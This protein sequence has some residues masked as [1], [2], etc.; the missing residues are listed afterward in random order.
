MPLLA[1]ESI[2]LA[3]ARPHDWRVRLRLPAVA[4]AISFAAASCSRS[5]L[6]LPPSRP[7]D[8]TGPG[9]SPPE[10][11]DAGPDIVDAPI[12]APFDA[13]ADVP[14]DVA[15]TDCLAAGVPA[16]YVITED[17]NLYRFYPPSSSFALIGA[18]D[19]ADD[20]AVIEIA[21]DRA[22]QALVEFS[23]SNLFSVDTKN[24]SCAPTSF[25]PGYNYHKFGMAFSANLSDS[26]ETLFIA[27]HTGQKFGAIELP[28][29]TLK[30]IGPYGLVG[31]ME[32]TGTAGGRLYGY[33][34]DIQYPEKGPLFYQV[35]QTGIFYEGGHLAFG[36]DATTRRIATWGDDV[37]FF[38][39]TAGADSV[40][41]HYEAPIPFGNS[42]DLTQVA[43]APGVVVAAGV[44]TCA[45]Q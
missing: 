30:D 29:F 9:G 5:A 7:L 44:S 13:P 17:K 25:V 20:N 40:V 37:Y 28:S 26:G 32:L 11:G 39:S 8:D 43:T 33:G 12:D 45:Q 34:S 41:T 4:L 1:A 6:E 3:S 2:D 14:I 24:A 19:C 10:S 42:P 16:I 35:E 38:T 31:N 22:G 21:V 27:S 23:D 36:A 15:I 18:L